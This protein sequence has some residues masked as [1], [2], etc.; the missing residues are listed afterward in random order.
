[1]SAIFGETLTFGQEN[2]PDI[3]LVAFGDEHYARYE[4]PDGYTVIYDT[5]LG[6]FCYARLSD[7]AFVSSRVPATDLPPADLRRHL[8][9]SEAVRLEKLQEEGHGHGGPATA[10]SPVSASAPSRTLGPNNGLL[11]GRVLSTGAVRGLTILVEFQDVRSTTTAADVNDMLNGANYTR[12]GNFSSAREYFR[13]VSNGKLDYTND[14]VGPFRLS[15]NRSF[16]FQNLLVR[17]AM[18]LAAASGVDFSRYDSRGEGIIDAVNILYAGQSQYNGE[19]WP[20]NH[21]ISLRF[22][23]MRTNLY[24]LTGLGR[25]PSDLSI[26]TFCH[27]NGHLL[28]RFPDMYDYGERDGDIRPSAGIGYYCLMGA[29]NHL[30]HGRTPAPVSAYLRD[31][32]GWCDTR[33]VLNTGGEFETRHGDYGTVMKFTTPVPNEYFIVENR[34]QIGLDRFLPSSGLAVYHCDTRGSN[35]FQDGTPSRHYQ[36]AL[37]QADGHLDLEHNIN[38]GDGTDMFGAVSGVALSDATSPASRMWDGS[39][40][41][42]VISKIDP[43]GQ[44]IRFT[45]GRPATSTVVTGTVAPALVIPDNAANGVS[46]TIA[47][48]QGGKVRQVKVNVD[49]THTYVGDLIVELVSPSGKVAVLHNRGGGSKDDLK[50]TFDPTSTPTLATLAGEPA[51]GN[52]VLRVRDLA[53]QDLG[54]LNRW[55]LEISVEPA[56]EPIRGHA[57][58]V[59][60]IPDNNSVGVGS[61]IALNQHG[62]VKRIKVDVDITHPYIGDLRVELLSP[63]GRR[64]LLHNRL[65]GDKDNLIASYDSMPASALAPLIG[66]PVLG[67]WVLHVSD[68]AGRDVGTLN[69][70][71]LELMT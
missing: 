18:E 44:S 5:E 4:T 7:G 26:G 42:L 61:T 56:L 66:S 6:L 45:A 52:W 30:N 64:A 24:L 32:A 70:W 43:P 50:T 69:K 67:T 10:A 11:E 19:L 53:G 27:E 13:L 59:L 54:K 71:S 23:A 34:S 21:S 29:G 39:D 49:I 62:T 16:Y 22:G 35:E 17:E 57:A 3:R 37:L 65:G 41:G 55:G 36:C 58:S 38:Q 46:S 15:R 60:A 12:N 2:G 51:V 1:M 28:C 68:H 48:A 63:N 9:E 14:V 20:H 8:Q 31:L 25:D 33:I 40:S 47:I